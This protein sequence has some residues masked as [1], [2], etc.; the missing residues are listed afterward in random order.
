MEGDGI[1]KGHL[2]YYSAI[3]YILWP[4]GI[5]CGHLVYFM[6]IC[7]HR[8]GL[9]YQ[10]KSGNPARKTVSIKHTK[11]FGR[12]F[13]I[14]SKMTYESQR[15]LLLLWIPPPDGVRGH[16]LGHNRRAP[17]HGSRVEEGELLTQGLFH[18]FV[19]HH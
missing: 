7:F 1:F 4:S 9:L 15:L 14:A 6:V 17:H 12:T 18:G 19:S 11:Q 3:W 2:V 8:F 5:Y 16:R 10:E 13:D